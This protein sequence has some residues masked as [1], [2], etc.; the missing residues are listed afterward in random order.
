MDTP[1]SGGVGAMNEAAAIRALFP[2]HTE[3][4]LAGLMNVP[5][6]TAHEWLHRRLSSKRRR[7]LTEALLT[8]CRERKEQL[9]ALES[10]LADRARSL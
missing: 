3:K 7:E 6:G 4:R 1:R 10:W 8:E 9:T 2:K 5:L